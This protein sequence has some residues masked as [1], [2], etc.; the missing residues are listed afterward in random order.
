M[1]NENPMSEDD[2]RKWA[3]EEFGQD[4]RTATMPGLCLVGEDV[5]GVMLPQGQGSTWADAVDDAQKTIAAGEWADREADA[6]TAPPHEWPAKV[7]PD[8][9]IGMDTDLAHLQRA[10]TAIRESAIDAERESVDR[11]DPRD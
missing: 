11:T 1:E 8:A 10:W 2:A 4:A 6:Q 7:R 9:A 3:V 5:D